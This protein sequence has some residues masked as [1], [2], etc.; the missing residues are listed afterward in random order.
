MVQ[1]EFTHSNKT[2]IVRIMEAASRCQHQQIELKTSKERS[3]KNL[4]SAG[5]DNPFNLR[6]DLVFVKRGRSL[7]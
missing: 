4:S 2:N 6:E 5:Y 7:T 3:I 1:V